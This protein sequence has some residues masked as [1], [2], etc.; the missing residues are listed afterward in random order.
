MESIACRVSWLYVRQAVKSSRQHS[1]YGRE[2]QVGATHHDPVGEEGFEGD[3]HGRGEFVSIV[4]GVEIGMVVCC[5]L[6]V[7][8][9]S[10]SA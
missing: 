5:I 9:A 7:T 1:V 3:T 8:T 4:L 2:A 6:Y 10:L